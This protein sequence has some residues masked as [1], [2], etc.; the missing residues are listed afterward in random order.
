MTRAEV[1]AQVAIRLSAQLADAGLAATDVTNGLK[2][3][4]DDALRSLGYAEADLA[5]A[6]PSDAPGFILM[7]KYHT[8]RLVLEKVADRF[9]VTTG[10]DS[11]RLN[12]VIANLEK[13]LARAEADVIR[14]FGALVVAD[15]GGVIVVD[16]N[17]LDPSADE[18]AA[19][20]A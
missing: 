8:L 14:W 7:A 17:Y 10:G 1:A 5:T 16:L 11:Y 4:I 20:G 2:E 12:Q 13:L 6:A 15:D 3:P 18:L 9:D 19:V